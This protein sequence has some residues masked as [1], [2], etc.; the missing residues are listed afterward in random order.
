MDIRRTLTSMIDVMMQAQQREKLNEDHNARL[1]ATV[2]KLLTESNERLQL[3]LKERMQALEDKNHM[4]QELDRVK[5]VM[6]ELQQD[7]VC[8]GFPLSMLP[9][10][11]LPLSVLPLSVL[12]LSMLPLSMLPL[13]LNPTLVNFSLAKQSF[14]CQFFH[15][16]TMPLL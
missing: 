13:S 7:K 11:V 1:S 5:T 12:P 2:D 4:Q 16:Q 14:S 10:S 15:G 9:L 6:E 3:H 8:E